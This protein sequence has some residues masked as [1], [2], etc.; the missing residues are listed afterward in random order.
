MRTR[1]LPQN[2]NTFADP[3]VTEEELI[4]AVVRM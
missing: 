2:D 1:A 4:G 3:F